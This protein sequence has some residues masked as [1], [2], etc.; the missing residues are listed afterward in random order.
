MNYRMN[1]MYDV[2]GGREGKMARRQLE[3]I[4][5]MAQDLLCTIRDED[6]LKEWVQ[7]KLATV[8]DRLSMIHS[9]MSYEDRPSGFLGKHAS[10]EYRGHTFPGYNKPIRNSGSSQHKMMVLAKKGDKVKLVRFGH[11]AYGHNYS[12][13][14]KQN[15]L[16][17][18]AGIRGKD[19][20][21][22]KDDKFSAN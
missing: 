7:V 15:Y 8:H 20:Q 11:R 1:P 4:C 14:A 3:E 6:D 12:S 9:Y 22:T 13:K 10:I 17:R 5:D 18:S 19:G 2:V 21:L 16:K